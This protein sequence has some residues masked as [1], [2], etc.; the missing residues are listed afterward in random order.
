MNLS[1]IGKLLEKWLISKSM[2]RILEIS[3]YGFAI[4]FLAYL[5]N[6]LTSGNWWDWRVALGGMFTTLAVSI[7]SGLQKELRDKQK[8]AEKILKTVEAD[9]NGVAG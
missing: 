5:G 3:I 4:S 7:I 8:E 9:G 1:F 6:A 2:A